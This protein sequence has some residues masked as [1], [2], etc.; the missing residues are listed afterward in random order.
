MQDK[1]PDS[2]VLDDNNL[3]VVTTPEYVKDSI[4]EAIEEHAKSRNHPYATQAEP[5][6]VTLSNETDSDSEIT[7]ATSKAVKKAYDLANAANQN[8]LNN[9]SN[10][11]LEKKQNGADIPNKPEFLSNIGAISENGG[12]YPGSFQFQQ[13]ETTPKES[14]PVK[15]VS[16]PHQ[17]PNKLVAFTNYGWYDNDIQTGIVRGG[18]VDT[19]GY[20][21]DINTRR[22]FAVDKW[23]ITIN[24]DFQWGGI[25]MLRPDGT[26]WRIEGIPNDATYLLNFIDRNANGSNKSVQTLPK[27]FGTIMSTSQYYSDPHSGV[28]KKISPEVKLYS[29]GSFEIND[30]SKGITAERLSEGNYLIKGILGFSAVSIEDSI[31][32]PLCKNK[33][34]MIWVDHEILPDGTIKLMTYHREH[35]SAPAFARNIREGYADGNLI[36][37]P[38]GRFVSV[39][40]QMPA[41]KGE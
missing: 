29:D 34:P 8:A 14:N 22:A 41:V 39:R 13:I 24:P 10:L 4:K 18:G 12:V 16:T 30:D 33:L 21:V 3:V 19:F 32:L 38:D 25:S 11:Y 28:V 37:I 1:K 15:I 31:E 36:D 17:E 9:S 26:F 5:G 2:T 27:G 7:V 40:V 35:S 6:F 20:A 23:G